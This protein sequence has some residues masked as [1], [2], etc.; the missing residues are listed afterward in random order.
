[1]PGII[2]DRIH[3]MIPAAMEDDESPRGQFRQDSTARATIA[4][5]PDHDMKFAVLNRWTLG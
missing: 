4:I 2:A 1:M 5:E 3:I